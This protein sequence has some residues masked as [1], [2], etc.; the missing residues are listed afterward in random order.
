MSTERRS[1]ITVLIAPRAAARPRLRPYQR[2]NLDRIE[3]AYRAGRNAPLYCA[4]TGSGKGIV[5]AEFACR[6]AHSGERVLLLGHRDE[7]VFLDKIYRLIR[8]I[9]NHCRLFAGLDIF[10]FDCLKS[11]FPIVAI[12]QLV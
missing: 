7:I 10:L 3:A 4:P 2:D 9:A 5:V 8:Q 11:L 1:P 12:T 6:A